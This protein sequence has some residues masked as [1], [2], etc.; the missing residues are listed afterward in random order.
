MTKARVV[1]KIRNAVSIGGR[2]RARTRQ[3]RK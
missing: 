1:A 3:A 2:L